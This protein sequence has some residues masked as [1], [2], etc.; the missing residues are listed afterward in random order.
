MP[1][2]NI[3][4]AFLAAVATVCA[5]DG[6]ALFAVAWRAP[7]SSPAYERKFRA[8]KV[9]RVAVFA[10]LLVSQAAL[11]VARAATHRRAVAASR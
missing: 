11:L 5:L 6:A 10:V 9:A 7:A 1:F 4:L 3:E 8:F 2:S